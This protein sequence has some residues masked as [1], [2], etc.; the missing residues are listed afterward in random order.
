MSK[1]VGELARSLIALGLSAT[2][3]SLEQVREKTFLYLQGQIEFCQ[4]TIKL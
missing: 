2:V 1:D 4:V 3:R